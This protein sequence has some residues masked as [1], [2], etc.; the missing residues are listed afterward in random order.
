[1]LDGGHP[2]AGGV[3]ERRAHRGVDHMAP[4]GADLGA[5]AIEPAEDDAGVDGRGVQRDRHLLAAVQRDAGAA[6]DRLEGSLRSA[7]RHLGPVCG[8][9]GW[10]VGSPAGGMPRARDERTR[11]A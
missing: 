8:L 7:V 11:K 2:V 5:G 4:G 10:Q 6:G 3:A 9:S 1:M